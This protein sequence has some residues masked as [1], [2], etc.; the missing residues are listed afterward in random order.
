MQ[1]FIYY[2]PF[3]CFFLLS[4][5]FLPCRTAS[6]PSSTPPSLL[7][8]FA[9]NVH[10]FTGSLFPHLPNVFALDSRLAS[11]K[12]L[13][14]SPRPPWPHSIHLARPRR[15]RWHRFSRTC[16]GPV[17]RNCGCDCNVSFSSKRCILFYFTDL[18]SISSTFRDSI[19]EPEPHWT[20]RVFASTPNGGSIY[21]GGLHS[22]S[23]DSLSVATFRP[24]RQDNKK[25]PWR[26]RTLADFPN[27]KVLKLT[28]ADI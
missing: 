17:H 24:R 9:P 7:A 5:F 18:L 11:Q 2:R 10:L 20:S 27:R 12:T 1:L 28:M 15:S 22:F 8:L 14:Q 25:S 3:L 19:T 23:S 6:S 4:L 16:K 21:L 26:H 13:I